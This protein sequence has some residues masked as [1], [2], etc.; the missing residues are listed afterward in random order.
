MTRAKAALQLDWQQKYAQR[1]DQVK[2]SAIMELIKLT[3]QPGFISFAS[4][5]PD[6]ALF[7]NTALRDIAHDL[8][9]TRAETALQYGAAEGWFP[10]RELIA[11]RL[12]SQGFQAGPEN[13]LITQG[14]Q[15]SI[16]LTARL[17]LN[18]GDIVLLENPSYLAAIQA[19]DMCQAQYVTIP[20]DDMGMQV[21][22]LPE[23]LSSYAPKLIYTLPNFQNPTGITLAADRRKT[24]LRS[25]AERTIPILED[26]AYGDLWYEEK[27]IPSLAALDGGSEVV[28]STGTFSKTIAPGIRVAWVYA[29]VPVI[30]KLTIVKQV[31]DL[32]TNTFVQQMVHAYCAQG[33]LAPQIAQLRR[34]YKEKRDLMFRALAA[35]LPN[36]VTW[37]RPAGGMFLMVYLPEGMNAEAV[38]K[39]AIE[40]KVAFVPGQPFFPKGG[41]ENTMRLNFASPKTEEIEEGIKRLAE[42]IAKARSA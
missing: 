35:H 34:A 27:P 37:T 9:T 23:L 17:L 6:P 19:F 39:V 16:E 21:D 5:L 4:G 11:E 22:R 8:L 28:I 24:L 30:E 18:P 40:K 33:K 42:A 2:T 13:I 7:P 20:L 38:L 10:L 1:M 31:T 14:S 15:Q 32:H 26:N 12:S 36:D 41:G 3:A 25:A 29:P